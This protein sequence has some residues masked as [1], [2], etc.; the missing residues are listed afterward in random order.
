MNCNFRVQKVCP[1]LRPFVGCVMQFAIYQ[2]LNWCENTDSTK[3]NYF[4]H[5]CYKLCLFVM[6][7]SIIQDSVIA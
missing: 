1:A 4:T 2:E 3:Q 5:F 6:N 7:N